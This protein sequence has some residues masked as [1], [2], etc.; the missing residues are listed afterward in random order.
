MWNLKRRE[1]PSQGQV[2]KARFLKSRCRWGFIRSQGRKG[3]IG[4]KKWVMLSGT[5]VHT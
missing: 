3:S 4:D 1:I 2:G 5:H